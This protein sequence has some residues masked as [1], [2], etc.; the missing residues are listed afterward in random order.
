MVG[1]NKILTV[2]YGTFSCTLEGFDEP[3]GTMQAI[4]EYFRDLTAEDRYFGAEPPTPD[5]EMLHR[6]AEREMQRRVEARM[7]G[8]GLV[9]RPQEDAAT[10]AAPATP[11]ATI[12]GTQQTG[13]AAADAHPR[14]EATQAPP[15]ATP[16]DAGPEPVRKRVIAKDIVITATARNP[17][18]A[19]AAALAG[20]AAAAA[21]AATADSSSM[22]DKLSRIRQRLAANASQQAAATAQAQAQA[23]TA[24]EEAEAEREAEKTDRDAAMRASQDEAEEMAETP[25]IPEAAPEPV[26]LFEPPAV[27]PEIVSEPPLAPVVTGETEAAV[28]IEDAPDPKVAAAQLDEQHDDQDFEHAE[29]S[30]LSAYFDRDGEADDADDDL[31]DAEFEPETFDAEDEL[32]A[33]DFEAEHD[34]REDFD[35][36]V[37]FDADAELDTPDAVTGSDASEQA[38]S[39][40]VDMKALAAESYHDDAEFEAA[41]ADMLETDAAN[42]SKAA[43][44]EVFAEEDLRDRIRGIIGETGLDNGSEA[45]LLDELAEIERQATRRRTPNERAKFDAMLGKT[46]ETAAL[47]LE[48]ARNELE[49]A[50]SQRRRDTFEHMRVAV[51]ATRAEEEATGPRRPDILED[52]E[53]QRY[54]EALDDAQPLRAQTAPRAEPKE[55]SAPSV[56]EHPVSAPP[57]SERPAPQRPELVSE[58]PARPVITAAEP[59]ASPDAA[60]PV[61]VRPTPR[62]PARVEGTGRPRPEPQR[63]PLVLVSEQRVDATNPVKPVRPRRVTSVSRDVGVKLEPQPQQPQQ[64]SPLV[65][66]AEDRQAFKDFA[67]T[68]DAWLL[69]EQ[70]EAAAAYATHLKGQKE[71][72]RVELMSYVLAYNEH[73]IV[74]RED[75]LRG[76]GTLLRE[77]RLQRSESGGFCLSAASEFDEPARQY[78]AN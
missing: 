33:E 64:R 13:L 34:A 43:P 37:E 30:V 63:T 77:G 12:G 50:D 45:D 15:D 9:L 41:L 59:A 24:Q 29:A 3:F 48:T 66:T 78:A 38:E 22:S 71:F 46:D 20:T 5:A 62:R 31:N 36:E 60:A 8:N 65:M 55:T 58:R 6:I 40:P 69:D 14:A 49:Q 7:Q 56:P 52:R 21:T 1:P 75:M 16:V 4:A 47:L 32:D 25:A 35:A 51:D 42:S 61:A 68:V 53:I 17:Q 27:Q 54:R 70:I 23:K 74:S 2:S 10:D 76:F 72:S 18:G 67:E 44:Q 39:A 26:T 28:G 57:V 73:K 11:R 19:A